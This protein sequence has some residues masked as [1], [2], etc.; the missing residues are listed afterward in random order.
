LPTAFLE[1]TTSKTRLCAWFSPRRHILDERTRSRLEFVLEP[2][3][4]KSSGWSVDWA[5]RNNL[6]A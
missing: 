5:L 4:D 3:G 6:H 2:D 1:P